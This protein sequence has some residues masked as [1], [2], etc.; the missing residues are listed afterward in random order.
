[1]SSSIS[2]H[3]NPKKTHMLGAAVL[4]CHFA[5]QEGE[6]DAKK[7]DGSRIGQFSERPIFIILL[8]SIKKTY[9]TYSVLYQLPFHF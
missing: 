3:A 5:G 9:S 6:E 4:F 8:L 2:K 7:E 1:M